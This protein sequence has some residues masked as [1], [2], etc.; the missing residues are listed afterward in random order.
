VRFESSSEPAL[1]P[2]LRLP[3]RRSVRPAALPTVAP[4]RFSNV[5]DHHPARHGPGA[6]RL[7]D[8]RV[9]QILSLGVLSSYGM[10][11][12]GF[13]QKPAGIA[14]LIVSALTTQALGAWVIASSG[15]R[16]W[17]FDPLSPLITAL[18]LSLLLRT[19]SLWALG[20]AAVPAV[21]S[22]F[23]IRFEGKH[24][25]NP[26]NFGI[27]I[28][29]LAGQGWVSPSQ[30]GS[31]TWAAF[32]FAGLA[33]LVLTRAKRADVALA[34]LATFV[35]LL[36]L[37]ALYLGDPWSIPLKQMQSG[38]ILLFAFFMISDPR[39]TPDARSWRIAYGAA[40]ALLAGYLMF[41]LYLP[42]G[43]IYA[44]FLSA[45]L[46]PLIDRWS[47][48]PRSQRFQWSRPTA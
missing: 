5:I 4:A 45:P 44:L 30:W 10:L 32:L 18:S 20:L 17:A 9:W 7:R 22:K 2:V 12:L 24:V 6:V 21:G 15:A 48:R 11:V 36:F 27:V 41:V 14:V 47:A 25:F 40:V 38:A 16:S 29:L 33:G 31:R 8:P 37:R 23:L 28:L 35:G 1:L 19:D 13:D 34:F 39:T 3:F 42:E 43:L 26:A 46:V